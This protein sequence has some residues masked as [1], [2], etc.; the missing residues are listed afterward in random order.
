M[1]DAA[2]HMEKMYRWQRHIYDFT[3]RPY[4]LGRDHMLERLGVPQNGSVLEVGC[5]TGR[6][7]VHAAR[8][9]PRARYLGFDVAPVM[10]ETA[11][12]SVARVGLEKSIRLAQGD[13][14]N[15]DAQAMFGQAQFDRIFISY[16][17]S[18]IPDWK[19]VLE[20][21]ADHL[22]QGG[23]LLI[24]DFGSS[25]KLPRVFRTLLFKWLDMFSVH[26]RAELETEMRRIASVRGF[27][28]D[29]EPLY[30]GYAVWGMMRR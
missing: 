8:L 12:R 16:S 18:M 13:A 25:E 17:L 30:G 26:P 7:L 20:R 9:Y 14:T 3:R 11:Q 4:L 23:A 22:A 27:K 21:S 5:G 29:F 6:N 24:A 2:V 19:S 15:F 10:V 1:S 28:C